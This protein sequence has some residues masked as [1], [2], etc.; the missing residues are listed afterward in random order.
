MRTDLPEVLSIFG[1]QRVFKKEEPELFHVLCQ[2]HCLP[3][4]D[5]LVDVVEEL[6]FGA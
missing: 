6:D 5:T 1:R 4:R 3:G 2:L